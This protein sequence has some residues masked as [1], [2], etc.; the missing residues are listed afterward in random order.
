MNGTEKCRKQMAVRRFGASVGIKTA[1]NV[2]QVRLE[3]ATV[4]YS[5]FNFSY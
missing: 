2:C 1:G 5:A 4:K 3:E